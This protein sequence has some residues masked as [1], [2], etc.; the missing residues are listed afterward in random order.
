MMLLLYIHHMRKN[1]WHSQICIVT[2]VC[3]A[4]CVCSSKLCIFNK[5]KTELLNYVVYDGS[6]EYGWLMMLSQVGK[7]TRFWH[8]RGAYSLY[9]T[10]WN[11]STSP[12]SPGPPQVSAN[13]FLSMSGLF[14]GGGVGVENVQHFTLL[15]GLSS[16]RQIVKAKEKT[17]DV[18]TTPVIGARA[19][20]RQVPVD[21]QKLPGLGG[22]RNVLDFSPAHSNHVPGCNP[23]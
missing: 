7:H 17:Y 14:L 15:T 4:V 11:K 9:V 18:K 20:E 10:Q 23:R 21:W 12:L 1:T 8:S 2:Q 13:R 22:K 5:K 16:H 6:S 3:D 19:S